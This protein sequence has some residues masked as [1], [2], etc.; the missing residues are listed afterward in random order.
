M[1]DT[2]HFSLGDRRVSSADP[3][4]VIAEI[5]VNH[6]G[7]FSKACALVDVAVSAGADAVKFQTFRTSSLVTRDAPKAAYQLEQTGKGTQDEML[8]RLEFDH[9]TFI[10]LREYCGQKGI[11]FISTAF[12][13]ASLEEVISLAPKCLKWPSGE[14]TNLP[15]LA[16]AAKAGLPIILS[17]G[18]ADLD[19]IESAILTVA[20][21]GDPP[22][23]ILQC[24]SDYPALTEVQNL[25]TI[26]KMAEKFGKVTGFSDHTEGPWAAIAARAL[27]MAILEKHITL[28]RSSTGPDHAASMEPAAFS[29]LV[30]A[31]RAVEVGLGDGHK[32]PV[33][34]E[35]ETR[36]AARKSI[37]FSRA[38]DEGH[39]LAPA[40][41]S[42]KRPGTGISPADWSSFVGRK[43]VISVEPDQQLARS[44][45]E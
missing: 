35:L 18:M 13:E 24:V 14:I 44:D 17:T 25:R 31:L 15:L 8:A 28:D 34:S 23:A 5:G 22:L 32:R 20:E 11:D 19:E 30:A 2:P 33:A 26:P 40:D 41:L 1:S 21:A 12:D 36:R 4:Y 29:E 43:L 39:I 45:V 38:L 7:D 3:C 42:F 16:A 10:R 6:D 27:G 9:G 37:V